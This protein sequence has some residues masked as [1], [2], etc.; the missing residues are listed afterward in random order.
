[1]RISLRAIAGQRP[2]LTADPAE[3]LRPIPARATRSFWQG[4]R[5]QW[6]A[7]PDFRPL[8][9]KRLRNP[10]HIQMHT[11][12]PAASCQL[13]PNH[14]ELAGLALLTSRLAAADAA[15]HRAR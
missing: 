9:T 10:S 2:I 1:M 11:L 12:L 8:S 15:N 7:S 5:S 14:K 6:P 3:P 4:P 13:L